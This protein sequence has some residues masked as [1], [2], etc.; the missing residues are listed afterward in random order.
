MPTRRKPLRRRAARGPRLG[1]LLIALLIVAVAVAVAVIVGRQFA[2]YFAGHKAPPKIAVNESPTPTP[3]P[4]SVV[5]AAPSPSSTAVTSPRIALIIDDC[6]YSLPRDLRFLKLDIPVTLSI[7]PMTPHG[8]EVAE[9]AQAAGKSVMLHLPMEPQSSAAHPGPGE[10]TTEM[11]DDQVRAQTAADISS[12]PPLPGANNHMGSKA[13]SDPRVMRDVL[14]VL[15]RDH[16]FFIDSMT[17]LTSVGASTARE[18][19]V[20]TAVR[21]V[22]LDNQATVPYVEAQIKRLEAL[23]R[24]NG[25]AIAIGHPNPQTAQA[26]ET[27]VPQL[28]AAGF[29]FVTAQSLVK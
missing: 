26:L 4:T 19:G 17:A 20:P 6:G 2:G 14:S 8:K 28:Q 15:K 23:A 11:T 24:K 9:A 7:L 27:M 1:R 29:T 16:M 18:L 13:S 22:F 25:V 3:A 10:I 12:L 5:S 21:D